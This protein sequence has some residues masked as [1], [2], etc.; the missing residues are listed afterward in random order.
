M[1]D[2]VTLILGLFAVSAVFGMLVGRRLAAVSRRY[3]PSGAR[4]AAVGAV[5]A[6]AVDDVVRRSWERAGWKLTETSSTS[7]PVGGGDVD[8]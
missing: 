4:S 7:D 2:L 3:P 6:A 5:D 1:D 8:R